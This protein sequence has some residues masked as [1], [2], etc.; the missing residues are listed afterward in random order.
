MSTIQRFVYKAGTVMTPDGQ[1]VVT[2]NYLQLPYTVGIV[3][4]VV[5]GAADYTIEFTTDDMSGCAADFR[6]N[7]LPGL[8]YWQSDPL[9]QYTL[10]FP[11]TA[12]RLNIQSLTGELRLSV[13]QAPSSL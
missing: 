12:I 11:V 6:W 5:S 3:A 1:D 13:I 2:L 8:V 10:L 4:D 9:I 7:V